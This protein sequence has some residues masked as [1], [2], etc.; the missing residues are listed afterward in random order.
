LYR[1]VESREEL[2]SNI[3]YIDL[4]RPSSSV[5]NDNDEPTWTSPTQLAEE[6][7]LA[8]RG[9]R[10]IR[11]SQ[12]PRLFCDI[13]PTITFL[14]PSMTNARSYFTV[15]LEDRVVFSE[16]TTLEVVESTTNVDGILYKTSLVPG[17]WDTISKSSDASQYTI[18]Q[19][20]VQDASSSTPPTIFSAMFKFLYQTST[21]TIENFAI[22]AHMLSTTPFEQNDAGSSFSLETLLTMEEAYT[23]MMALDTAKSPDFFGWDFTT[24]SPDWSAGQCSPDPSAFSSPSQLMPRDEELLLLSPASSFG[25]DI[26]NYL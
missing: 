15:Y 6:R 26:A 3:I 22:A 2:P 14:A 9:Y 11:A 12:H 1:G 8:E 18:T 24:M 20:V 19:H 25:I 7:S 23:E 21:P 5:I 13:D 16:S 4:L 17:F 10:I